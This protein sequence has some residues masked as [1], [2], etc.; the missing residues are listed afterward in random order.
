MTTETTTTYHNTVAAW[1][2][3]K[4]DCKV[5][6]DGYDWRNVATIESPTTGKTIQVMT[7]YREDVRSAEVRE[8]FAYMEGCWMKATF[9]LGTQRTTY[10]LSAAAL[11][12]L[13]SIAY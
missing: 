9:G 12:E 5:T 11:R 1:T 6:F 3:K 8:F 10:R 4:F 7:D 2:A 13:L